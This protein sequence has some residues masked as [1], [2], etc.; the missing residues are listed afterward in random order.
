[1]GAKLKVIKHQE[2]THNMIITKLVTTIKNKFEKEANN[3]LNTRIQELKDENPNGNYSKNGYQVKQIHTLIGTLEILFP[4]LRYHTFDYEIL[5]ADLMQDLLEK[6]CVELYGHGLS[7]RRISTTLDSLGFKLSKSTV[8]I[9]CKSL[10]DNVISYFAKDLTEYE[11][12]VIHLDGKYFRVK[13]VNSNRKAVLLNVIGITTSGKK[14]HMHMDAKPTEDKQYIEQFLRDLKTRIG[15]TNA[16]FVIDG[17]NNLSATI[18]TIFPNAKVQRCLSHI[19]RNI[20]AGLKQYAGINQAK[21]IMNELNDILFYTNTKDISTKLELFLAKHSKYNFIFKTHLMSENVWTYLQLDTFVD[22]KTNNNIEGF[23]SMLES[24]TSQ[25]NCF[26]TSESLYRALIK[27]I[28]RYNDCTDLACEKQRPSKLKIDIN[29]IFKS[30][31]KI[32]LI[33]ICIKFNGK[34]RIN[35]EITKDDYDLIRGLLQTE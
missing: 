23:H 10:T 7:T 5:E 15:D 16:C 18:K 6:L 2:R 12:A 33:T 21:S 1:M 14:I 22:C 19:S 31:N 3:N 20:E 27:E 28:E 34:V 24:V 30:I 9:Y 13:D 29:N 4:R 32:N 35:K 17:N 25:H 26:E 11:F 8:A